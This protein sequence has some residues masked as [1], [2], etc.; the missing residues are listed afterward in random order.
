MGSA[1]DESEVARRIDEAFADARMP[2][3]E[4]ELAPPSIDAPYV[5]K[6]FLGKT[7]DDVESAT[8]HGSLYMEDFTYMTD[9]AVRYYLPS[10]LRIMLANR[11]DDELWLFLR[12]F[13]RRATG[14]DAAQ[15]AAIADWAE[16]LCDAWQSHGWMSRFSEEAA[17]LAGTFRR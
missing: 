6:H 13:L 14:L 1:R 8:F 11:T 9:G 5:I 7:R 3:T 4:A 10:V 15:R 16:Y 12:S 2:H 17:K